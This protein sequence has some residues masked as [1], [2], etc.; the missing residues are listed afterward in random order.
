M[1]I[2][3]EAESVP[4]NTAIAG[5]DTRIVG[6]LSSQVQKMPGFLWVANSF[7]GATGSPSP[8]NSEESVT[9]PSQAQPEFVGVGG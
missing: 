9:Q 4:K 3:A 8:A 6:R 5:F 2:R 1:R 7:T